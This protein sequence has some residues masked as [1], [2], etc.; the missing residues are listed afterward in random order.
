VRP[1]SE[2]LVLDNCSADG[3]QRLVRQ[4]FPEVR[5][6]ALPSNTGF[7]GAAN[8]AV[9]E[10][11][12]PYLMLVN[13][14]VVMSPTFVTE[15][16]CFAAARPD[17]GSLT[18]KLLRSAPGAGRAIVDSTGHVVSRSRWVA[19]RGEGEEDC[20]QY[21]RPDEVFGVSGAVPLYRR[22]MLED[23]RVRGEVFAESFFVYLEDVDVDWRARLRGWKAYYVPSAVAYH[24]RRSRGDRRP[25]EASV[26][27]HALKNRY[28]LMLRND[29]IVDCLRDA[30]TILPLEAMR[31][32]DFLRAAPRA[33]LGYL[34]VIRLLPQTLQ[35]RREI[36]SRVRTTR[37]EI[38]RWLQC[39]PSRQQVMERAWR[40]LSWR[41]GPQA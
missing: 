32:V 16:V 8:V 37:I 21:E 40:F 26:L 6:I 3:S 18:G 12:A 9:R 41:H 39:R 30:W 10:T 4:R 31:A 19:N 33:L 1:P 36:H 5:L 28:L 38:G 27:R 14:D 29:T 11:R 22:A 15:L 20:G 25:E 23:I 24:E 35:E 7:A 17:A 13:P 2:I 34:D